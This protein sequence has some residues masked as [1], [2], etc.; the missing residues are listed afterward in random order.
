MKA[1]NYEK[2]IMCSIAG[3]AGLRY[4]EICGLTWDDIEFTANTITINKQ[5]GSTGKGKYEIKEPKTDNSIRTVPMPAKLHQTLKEY[6]SKIILP[7]DRR[8]FQVQTSSSMAVNNVIKKNRARNNNSRYAPYLRHLVI[9]KR[10]RHP[11][12]CGFA[13]RH[14]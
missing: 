9:I 8:L 5:L 14:H 6:K 7:I 1:L 11:D 10:C 3:Y 13:W 2:H 12:G 4:G